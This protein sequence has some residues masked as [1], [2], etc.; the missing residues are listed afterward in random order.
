MYPQILS[1]IVTDTRFL[2]LN[3]DC[4]NNRD[5]LYLNIKDKNN[6]FENACNNNNLEI[7]KFFYHKYGYDICDNYYKYYTG[8]YIIHFDLIKFFFENKKFKQKILN[9]V[10]CLQKY[11]ILLIKFIYNIIVNMAKNNHYDLTKMLLE[12][13]S[14][15]L[16]ESITGGDQMSGIFSNIAEYGHLEILKLLHEKGSNPCGNISAMNNACKSGNVEVIKYLLTFEQT[17]PTIEGYINAIKQDH[18]DMVDFLLTYDPKMK[19]NPIDNSTLA[20]TAFDVIIKYRSYKV[21]KLLSN[22]YCD[23]MSIKDK[24]YLKKIIDKYN[25]KKLTIST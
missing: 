12:D 5:L 10:F 21:F 6:F 3:K 18:V 20:R 25:E 15:L 4:S 1:K 14:H 11:D 19:L 9:K 13:Y 17:I 2:L 8:E 23:R 22:K 24:E 16:S 7:V